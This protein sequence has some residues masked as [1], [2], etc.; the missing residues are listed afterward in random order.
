MFSQ[1][2]RINDIYSSFTGLTKEF[3]CVMM[4]GETWSTLY[5]HDAMIV[6]T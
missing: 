1:E 4:Y 3:Y 5:L 6:Q 2:C